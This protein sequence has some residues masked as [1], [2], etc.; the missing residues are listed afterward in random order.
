MA[1]AIS[2]AAVVAVSRRFLIRLDELHLLALEQLKPFES[3][4]LPFDLLA[5]FEQ[6]LKMS[7]K[8][9]YEFFFVER[10]LISPLLFGVVVERTP[11]I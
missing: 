3:F 11:Y 8:W 2:L 7:F 10:L 4:K 6:F 1:I 5:T 9:T